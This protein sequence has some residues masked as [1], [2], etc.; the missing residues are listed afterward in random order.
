[1]PPKLL[2]D[3]MDHG[4]NMLVRTQDRCFD[5]GSTPPLTHLFAV[6]LLKDAHKTLQGP[7]FGPSWDPTS[8]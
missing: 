4:S 2:G 7:R 3:K 1:M 8:E 6:V 5:H